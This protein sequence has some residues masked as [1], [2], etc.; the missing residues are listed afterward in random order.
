M[1]DAAKLI[2]LVPKID[3]VSLY[4]DYIYY[5]RF[6][7]K[8]F[9]K[10][11]TFFLTSIPFS[12]DEKNYI[13]NTFLLYII[14][15]YF[16][17]FEAKGCLEITVNMW[18]NWHFKITCSRILAFKDWTHNSHWQHMVVFY[19][20]QTHLGIFTSIFLHFCANL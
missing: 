7:L 8:I 14:I 10:E 9:W 2:N 12:Q 1:I 6:G 13:Q 15:I 11:F 5:R 3:N 19:L 20:K 4:H 18:V 17:I 16:H